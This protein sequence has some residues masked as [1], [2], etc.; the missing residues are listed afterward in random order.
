M[1][2]VQLRISCYITLVQSNVVNLTITVRPYNYSIRQIRKYLSLK[3][4]KDEYF[5][6]M[7]VHVS[8]ICMTNLVVNIRS[9]RRIVD[10]T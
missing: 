9:V 3:F 2:Y 1:V 8:Y 4:L 7:S 10:W 5:I 6:I